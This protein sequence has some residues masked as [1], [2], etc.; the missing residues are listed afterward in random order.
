MFF[1][2][3]KQEINDLYWGMYN[4]VDDPDIYAITSTYNKFVL[5]NRSTDKNY[6]IN[7]SDRDIQN[8][9]FVISQDSK[10]QVKYNKK[11][12]TYVNR[13]ITLSYSTFDEFYEMLVINKIRMLTTFLDQVKSLP[14]A[15]FY[16]L[17][18]LFWTIKIK[19]NDK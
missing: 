4:L 1:Q 19:E 2:I 12:L 13:L 7:L 3:D 17:D 9:C 16:E 8:L 6:L 10:L 5:A 11:Y 15:E 14:V 18:T